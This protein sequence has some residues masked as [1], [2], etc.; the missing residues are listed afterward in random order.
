MIDRKAFTRNSPRIAAETKGKV[1]LFTVGISSPA[2]L[3]ESGACVPAV[4]ATAVD[5]TRNPIARI[6]ARSS[7]DK[8][9]RRKISEKSL[10]FSTVVRNE[11]LALTS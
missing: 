8:R 9:A 5:V 4:K 2:N 6:P 7:R 3:R 11:R 1:A 10:V